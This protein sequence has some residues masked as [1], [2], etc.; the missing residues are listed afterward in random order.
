[1]Q[2]RNASSNTHSNVTKNSD[3]NA[4]TP[5]TGTKDL[6]MFQSNVQILTTPSLVRS[7]LSK[8]PNCVLTALW[9]LAGIFQRSCGMN[10]NMNRS[11]Y[12]MYMENRNHVWQDNN[13]LNLQS[14]PMRSMRYS[15]VMHDLIYI[16]RC[17]GASVSTVRGV[18]A[19]WCSRAKRENFSRI[20]YSCYLE[21][22]NHTTQSTRFSLEALI[23]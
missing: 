23:D 8:H 20:T 19:C 3:T 13:V 11:M 7:H 12:A 14:R 21:N 18:R 9:S 10:R 15:Y 17:E 5:H 16:L 6:S 22:I 1:M 2:D 4:R